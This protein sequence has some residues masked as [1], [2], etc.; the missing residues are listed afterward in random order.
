MT[1]KE[2]LLEAIAPLN[3]GILA[4][5]SDR[6]TVNHLIEKL[7]T[8]NPH[9]QPLEAKEIL[10]GN[11]RLLYTTNREIL[12]LGRFP[13]LQL[14]N[15]YQCIRMNQAKLYNF[16]EIVGVPFLEGLVSVAASFEAVSECRVNVK[17][18]R[19]I[20]GL[21]RIIG[22]SN[23]D[24]AIA[25]IEAG[26]KFPP[27]DFNLANRDRLGWLEVTYLDPDLRIGRGNQGNVFV[28]TKEK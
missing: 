28:L 2:A 19:S 9:P 4:T 27:I 10:D 1:E 13:L 7:E 3:R 6:A 24:A 25:A 14:G 22:Y 26:K 12:G 20:V 5:E 8:I 21:Q 18:E 15:V 11:W 16:A 17:F 23:P